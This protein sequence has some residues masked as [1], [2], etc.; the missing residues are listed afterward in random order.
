MAGNLFL[1]CLYHSVCILIGTQ[2]WP[3]GSQFPRAPAIFAMTDQQNEEFDPRVGGDSR[4]RPRATH[5][6]AKISGRDISH[7]QFDWIKKRAYARACRRAAAAGGTRYRGRWCT[8]R[9]LQGRRQGTLPGSAGSTSPPALRNVPRTQHASRR[10]RVLSYN[11]GGV[12]AELYDLLCRWIGQQKEADIVLLQEI[13]HGL[14]REESTWNIPGWS[15]VVAPDARNRHSGVAAIISHRV[16]GPDNISFCSWAPGR[17]LQIRCEGAKASIDVF[18][19][20]QWVRNAAYPEQREVQRTQVWNALSRALN[21][22]PAR[23]LLVIGG[24]FNAALLPERGLVGAG[25]HRHGGTNHDTDLNA[26]LQ[27][28]GLCALNTWGQARPSSS[29]TFLNGQQSSQV[30]FLLTRRNAADQEA[31]RARP[32]ELNLAPWRHGPRHRP[33]QANIP[34]VAGWWLSQRKHQTPRYDRADMQETLAKGDVRALTFRS[35]IEHVVQ[36]AVGRLTLSQLNE[37]LLAKCRHHFPARRRRRARAGEHELVIHR[38][39]E[40]W[41]WHRAM[42]RVPRQGPRRNLRQVVEAWKRYAKFLRSWRALR[43][44]SRFARRQW[45]Q[46]QIQCAQQ[47]ANRHDYRAVYVVVQAIAPKRRREV[48]RIRGP[49]GQ[50]LSKEQQLQ[51]VHSYFADAFSAEPYDSYLSSCADPQF[52]RQEVLGALQELKSRKA[53]PDT[54]VMAEIWQLTPEVFTSYFLTL[55]GEHRV[56][57]SR[58][59]SDMTDCT[60]SLLPKPGK[61]SRRPQDLR[62]L[63]LQDPSSKLLATM[64]KGRLMEIVRPYLM[65]KPQFAYVE[66]R[67]IDQAISRVFRRCSRVRDLLRRGVRSV[68]DRRAGLDAHQCRGGAL[69]SIDLSRAFDMVPRWALSAS[70]HRASVPEDLHDLILDI[71]QDCQYR[72][73]I[74]EQERQFPMQRG[75]RQGCSLSPLLFAIFTGWL[76]DELCSRVGQEWADEFITLYADDSLLQWIINSTADLDHMCKCIRATF[77]LLTATGMQV[78][79]AKSQLIIQLQGAAGKRWLKAHL[80]RAKEGFTVSVGT[81]SHPILLPR[82]H[83]FTYLGVVA[84]LGGFEMQ[85]CKH[86]LRTGAQVRHRL[87]RVL[88]SAGLRVRQRAVLYQACVRSSFLYGQHAVGLTSGVLRKLEA[89]DAKNLRGITRS[90][91]HLWH[92]RSQTLRERLGLRSVHHMLEK[93]YRSRSKRSQDTESKHWFLDQWTWLRSADLSSSGDTGGLHPAACSRA[94]ACDQC[95]QYFSSMGQV[96]KHMRRTHGTEHRSA[97]PTSPRWNRHML[98]GM[99]HCRH[100]GKKFTRVEGFRKHIRKSCIVLHGR[101]NGDTAQTQEGEEPSEVEKPQGHSCRASPNVQEDASLMQTP[102]FRNMLLQNWR[103]VLQ[104]PQYGP[105]LRTYCVVCGQWVSMLGPGVK[106]HIRLMHPAEWSFK[107][108]AASRCSSLTLSVATPCAYC[109]TQVKDIRMHHKRCSAIFQASLA[110]AIVRQDKNGRGDGA[111]SVQGG[112]GPASRG[113]GH[114]NTLLFWRVRSGQEVRAGDGGRGQGPAAG[115]E[116]PEGTEQGCPGR[117]GLEG[118]SIFLHGT[119][120]VGEQG[121]RQ[122]GGSLGGRSQP[123]WREAAGLGD[124]TPTPG[125]CQDG[126]TSRG[127]VGSHPHRYQLHA[128]HGCDAGG[129]LRPDEADSRTVAREVHGRE[130]YREPPGDA[131]ACPARRDPGPHGQDRGVGGAAP[132]VHHYWLD[133]RGFHQAQPCLSILSMESRDEDP[134]ALRDPAF[135]PHGSPHPCADTAGDGGS[136]EC[137]DQ[138]SVDEAAVQGPQRGGGPLPAVALPATVTGGEVPRCSDG[139]LGVRLSQAGRAAAPPGPWTEAA[140]DEGAGAS[141][142]RGALH[143]LDSTRPDVEPRSPQH[144]EGD[145]G[146]EVGR[147]PITLRVSLPAVPTAQ[148]TNSGNVCYVNAVAQALAWLGA[149]SERPKDCYGRAAMALQKVLASGKQTLPGSLPWMPIFADWPQLHRQQDAGSFCAHL[150]AYAQ[151]RAYLGEWQ[152]RLADPCVIVDSGPLLAPISVEVQG[153]TL[154]GVIDRWS[155]QHTMHGLYQPGGA[156]VLQLKRYACSDGE[157]SKC[158]NLVC[159]RPGE[160][161]GLPVFLASTGL[162]M[163]ADTYRIVSCVFHTGHSLHSG[164]YQAALCTSHVGKASSPQTCTPSW[165]YRICDD[166]RKPRQS[167]TKEIQHID[168]NVYLVGLLRDPGGA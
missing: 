75:I 44:A 122:P 142:P 10:L 48:V 97:R 98:D 23:N 145:R 17:V 113:A 4:P 2:L 45:L 157:T 29:A 43:R 114:V 128:F 6:A 141:V 129:G 50:L 63:G 147:A 85:T 64:I 82:V 74:G 165:S 55:F 51:E 30:D 87:L 102:A 60:L 125:G 46:D 76:Y 18:C 78:N 53:V 99:P 83:H 135:V 106:Q 116:V 126:D 144:R 112:P 32:I 160:R 136:A 161:I 107:D 131:D 120:L 162:D 3:R 93:L 25:V 40:M 92:E 117:Q 163:R 166:N 56:A 16:A 57:T 65:S 127:G 119:G 41:Q 151:P 140:P 111:G 59:P 52:T 31:R 68:H 33:V 143:G 108:F 130:S 110:E 89:Q 159:C 132:K 167:R 12:T 69:L 22:V 138:V 67:S 72:I 11:V 81:P 154:Q 77:D 104:H 28:H 66:G 38:I 36:L 155:H 156:L 115:V 90:P 42:R 39:R 84:S 124:T 73:K 146:G 8:L 20:Y 118:S 24:D 62:P 109:G 54:S 168:S 7:T 133:G 37:Q 164:H 19:V 153:S 34:W 94:V 149:C 15:F 148:L 150:L 47:A 1:Y 139:T 101:C 71:H 26:L 95:G 134:G 137:P 13:H 61:P 79:A 58:L 49:Q 96:R 70:L 80:H 100:C 27:T 9:D 123:E 105:S 158:T 103:S 5:S 86:R 14:G 121:P 91:A 21:A 35:E 88:H 152:A